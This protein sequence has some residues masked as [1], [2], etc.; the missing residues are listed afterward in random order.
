LLIIEIDARCIRQVNQ[1]T[2]LA[3]LDEAKVREVAFIQTWQGDK[4]RVRSRRGLGPL[5]ATQ[6]NHPSETHRGP[7]RQNDVTRLRNNDELLRSGAA[8]PG[9]YRENMPLTNVLEELRGPLGWI[10]HRLRLISHDTD[11][12]GTIDIGLS[13]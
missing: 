13:G 5:G 7:F 11:P 3:R 4:S 9:G 10:S 8:N 1:V 12:R 2:L 6:L